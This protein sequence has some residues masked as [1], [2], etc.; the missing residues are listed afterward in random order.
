VIDILMFTDKPG[1][2][3]VQSGPAVTSYCYDHTAQRNAP[4][5]EPPYKVLATIH[6][7]GVESKQDDMAFSLMSITFQEHKRAGVIER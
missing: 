1:D 7:K 4:L 5:S 2:F 6:W 3:S